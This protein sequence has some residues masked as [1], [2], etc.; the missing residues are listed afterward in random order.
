MNLLRT[1]TVAAA[2]GVVAPVAPAAPA[3]ERAPTPTR[4]PDPIGD[5]VDL[6]FLTKKRPVRITVQFLQE[7]KT[8]SDRWKAELRT[9]FAAFDRNHDGTL[10]K[11]ETGYIFPVTSFRQLLQSNYYYGLNYSPNQGKTVPMADVDK[12]ENG[13]VTFA[14]FAEYYHDATRELVKPFAV[15]VYSQDTSAVT[16]DLFARLDKNKDGKLSEEEVRAAEKALLA[17][18]SDEDE[19]VSFQELAANPFLPS[20]TVDSNNGGMMGGG[21][22]GRPAARVN[23]PTDITLYSGPIPGTIVQ[24]IINRYDRNSDF[25]LTTEEVGFDKATFARLDR[26][27]DGKISPLELDVW[28]TGQPDGRVTI[29]NSEK[30]GKG[31]LLA[32][33]A[34][35]ESK[36]EGFAVSQPEPH[37]LVIRLG[38]QTLDLG[39]STNVAYAPNPNVLDQ[40]LQAFFPRGKDVIEEKDIVAPQF[41]LIRLIFDAAD[42]N[43]DGKLTKDEVRK[44]AGLQAGIASLGVT[45]GYNSRTPNF[46]QVMDENSDGRLSLKELRTAW[47]RLIALEEEGKKAITEEVLQSS[48]VIRVGSRMAVQTDQTLQ[49]YAYNQYAYVRQ[50]A[51]ANQP[52]RGPKWF[53]KLDRNLD[54][55]VSRAEFIGSAEDFAAIDTDKDGLISLAEAE[56]YDTKVRPQPKPEAKRDETPASPGKSKPAPPEKTDPTAP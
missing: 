56:A 6:I 16:K 19:C 33:A 39:I 47:K 12:N 40:Q 17:I 18:D 46:F 3:L 1:L 31:T 44:Y 9:L 30:P 28:R 7:G 8:V 14:E 43:G 23:T 37:R 54:G 15:P 21:M 20:T 10:D 52:V 26:N 2:I 48:A 32:R 36:L 13:Q 50:P 53:A 55:D 25:E 24:Q 27:K 38:A 22:M 45:A 29:D 4:V 42:F 41:Q 11:T 5:T 49:G 34:D 51:Q 35:G